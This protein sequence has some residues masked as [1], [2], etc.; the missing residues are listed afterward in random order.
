M[1]MFLFVISILLLGCSTNSQ[2]KTENL[3][4]VKE[5]QEKSKRE[6]YSR[7]RLTSLSQ[8]QRQLPPAVIEANRVNASQSGG[9]HTVYFSRFPK[10]D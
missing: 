7:A 5:K 6:N 2:P 8:P 4:S 3:E 1:K 10:A 9:S